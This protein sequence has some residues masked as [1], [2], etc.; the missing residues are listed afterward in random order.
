MRMTDEAFYLWCVALKP[1]RYCRRRFI[2]PVCP[3]RAEEAMSCKP[4]HACK[5]DWLHRTTRPARDVWRT[6][7]TT[8]GTTVCRGCDG[9]VPLGPANDTP[10]VLVEIRAAEIAANALDGVGLSGHAPDHCTGEHCWH[11]YEEFDNSAGP[12]C[13]CDHPGPILPGVDNECQ[14]GY[15]VNCITTHVDHEQTD[16]AYSTRMD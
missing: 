1:C 8:V 3:V 9:Y 2:G 4:R 16:Y 6:T 13:Y 12:C 7:L 14:T 10:E 15:L 11:F 5:C